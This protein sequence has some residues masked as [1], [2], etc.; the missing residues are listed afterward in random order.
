M[1]DFLKNLP[2]LAKDKHNE[3]KKFFAKLKSKP[4]KN[5]DYVMQ[6]L[7]DAE[8]KKNGLFNLCQLL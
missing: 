8:F 2:K 1:Q 5:L 4:P 6:E 7:H 3:N